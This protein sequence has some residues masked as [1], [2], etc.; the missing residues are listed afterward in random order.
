[1]LPT[2]GTFNFQSIRVELIIREAFER[3]GI[4]GEFTDPQKLSSARR[5]IDLLLLEWISKSVNLWTIEASYLSLAT[6]QVQYTL[7]VIVSDIIQV[8]LRTSTRQLNGVAASSN[9]GVAAEAFDGNP[10]TACTQNAGDGNISYDYGAGVTQQINFVGVQ[11]NNNVVYSIVVES[12]VDT[13]AWLPLVTIPASTFITGAIVWVDVPT[14]VDARAYRIRETGGAT[15][16][17][18][19]I[20]FNNNVLDMPISNVSRYEYLTY[21]NKRLQGRPSIY[22]LNRQITPV[23]N[24]WPAPSD[25]YNCLQYSYIQMIQDT[26]AFSTDALQI[27]SRFYPALIWGLSYHLALKYNPQ[28]AGLFKGEYEQSF[29]LATIEDSE[30]VVISITGDINYGEL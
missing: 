1:M 5:S 13:V 8:N 25:Q 2:S 19:E 3:I 27:P 24:L 16:N 9:G 17:I 23:L 7:P 26:G 12:S 28:Q 14:P 15:L 21:P 18:Q 10:L 6:S 4:L 20:Y 11:S 29:K 22:Y 30:N